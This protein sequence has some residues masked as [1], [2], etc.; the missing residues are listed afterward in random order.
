MAIQVASYDK[1]EQQHMQYNH[2]MWESRM[3]RVY[4]ELISN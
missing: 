3:G 1:N 2:I 4:A